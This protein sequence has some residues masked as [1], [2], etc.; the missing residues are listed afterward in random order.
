MGEMI[1]EWDERK[2]ISNIQKHGISFNDASQVFFDPHRETIVDNR[3]N[4]SEQREIVIGK[5]MVYN[6]IVMLTVI[7]T[8]KPNTY[9][10][11]SARKANKKEINAYYGY[12]S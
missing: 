7:V 4:Y 11:I 6:S 12:H 9:R 3:K 8:E 1:F 5:A 10:I 2:N